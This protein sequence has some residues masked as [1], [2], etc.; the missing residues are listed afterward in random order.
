[1]LSQSTCNI[2]RLRLSISSVIGYR[3]SCEQNEQNDKNESNAIY[4]ENG[5]I[6]EI[7]NYHR[8]T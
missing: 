4:F 5:Y 7:S 6:L 2:D 8:I 3:S 1:M